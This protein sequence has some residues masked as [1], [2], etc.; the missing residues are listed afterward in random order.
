[1][2]TPVWPATSAATMA[3]AASPRSPLMDAAAGTSLLEARARAAAALSQSAT[4]AT[5]PRTAGHP[6]AVLSRSVKTEPAPACGETSARRRKHDPAVSDE[7][8]DEA[9][10]RVRHLFPAG[11]DCEG[12]AAVRDLGDLG[13]SGVVALLLERRVDDR[14]GNR[15]VLLTGDQQH[16]PPL[17]I[18]GID[19]VLRPRVE[20]GGSRLEEDLG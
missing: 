4:T 15:M 14:P 16:R 6:T 7:P 20:V 1:M 8:L 3:P 13:N 10:G 11:V 19:L 9:E 2:A 18:L 17:G 12:M 5:S